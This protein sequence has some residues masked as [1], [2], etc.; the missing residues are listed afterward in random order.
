MRKNFA[1]LVAASLKTESFRGFDIGCSGG[2]DP[3]WRSFGDRLQAVGYDPV[4]EECERLKAAETL[5]GVDYVAGFVGLPPDHPWAQRVRNRPPKTE[6]K[7]RY[8]AGRVVERTEE[9]L[10]DAPLAEKLNDNAWNLATLADAS[11]PI[12]LIDELKRLDWSYLDVLK[13]DVDGP[14]FDILQSFAG[15]FD[16]LAVL[17]ASLEVSLVGGADETDNVLHNTDR[18]MRAH[19]FDLVGLGVRNYSMKSL[20]AR[21]AT[22]GAAQ[23]QTGRAYQADALYARDP[24]ADAASPSSA[25][26]MQPEKMAKLAA[27]FSIWG[28]PDSSAEILLKF[29]PLLEGLL[30]VD[31]GLDLLAAQAQGDPPDPVSY[32]D[33]I[34]AFEAGDPQFELPAWPTFTR[35]LQ[36]SA[37]IHAWRDP[38]KVLYPLENGPPRPKPRKSRS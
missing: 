12:F 8:S 13:I 20:P 5:P 11:K 2:I 26:V 7:S 36:I 18:F 37:L 38:A 25:V 29:R 22:T 23:T 17:G 24:A 1:A 34:A 14:D 27:L 9:R 3:A 10:R 16:D 35:S 30:D 15:R 4:I 6:P 19:G 28:Q 32:R 21:F 33:Y 31:G